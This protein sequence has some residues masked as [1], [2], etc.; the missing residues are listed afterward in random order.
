V[1]DLQIFLAALFVSAAGLN[2]I[3]NWLDVP[4]PIPLVLGG[5]VLG[6]IPGIP[7][8]QLDPDLV[9]LLFLPP[10][11]YATAF[12][13]DL[14]SLRADARVIAINAIGLTLA[15]AAVVGVIAHEM[16]GLPWAV[17]FALGAIV[18]PTDPAAATAVM[19]RVGA[20]RRLVNVLEGESLVNDATALVTFKVAVAVAVGESVSAEHTVLTFFGDVAGGVAI[21]L[22]V[23]W[24]IAEVRKRVDDV[25]TELTISLFSAYGAF[26]PADQL[27]VS[28]VLAVVACGLV[29]GFRAPEIASPESR[30]QGLALWSILTF[31]LNATLF[32]LIGLQLPTIVDGLSGRPAGEVIGYAA[33]ICGAVVAMRFIWTNLMTVVIRTLD[34]RES[35]RARRSNWQMRVVASWSG[36]RGA[37]SL[38]AALALPLSIN[39]RDLIQFITFSL[40]LVTVVGQGLTLPWLIRRLGVVED[41]T[42]E[43]DEETRA[44]LV[45]ARAAIERVDE[46]EGEE[47]TREGTI[48]RVRRLYEFRQR[49]FKIRAGKIED[50]DGL[51]EG[52]LAY[53]RLMHEIF[54]TQRQELVRLRNSRE[55]SAEVMRRVERE[56]DLEESRLEV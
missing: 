50:E 8:V 6:L 56:L 7:E 38:A 27:G 31:L 13:A 43:E 17:S 45:I 22:A 19:R 36:M 33:A 1:S 35:Q 53:Q 40:I 30:M 23:G 47:W 21:G 34:R 52:S 48:E 5:L 29:L 49:R 3:A 32:I 2:A 18:S 15:T 16:I 10:L 37:V 46:L 4:Y 11:L 39:D 54:A 20:P 28:G 24:V 51:E 25:N 12:F 44:R 14:R 9:L 55:I 26:V 41:G 42:E